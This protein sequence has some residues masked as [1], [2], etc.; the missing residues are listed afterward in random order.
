MRGLAQCDTK[1]QRS[2]AGVQLHVLRPH[3]VSIQKKIR[4]SL[5][6]WFCVPLREIANLPTL[7]ERMP[8]SKLLTRIQEISHKAV[9]D[10]VAVAFYDYQTSLRFAVRGDRPFHAASTF[11]AAVLLAVLKAVEEGRVRWDDR[12]QV[13]N[14]FLSIVDGSP[15]RIERTRDADASAHRAIGGSMSIRELAEVMV[16]RSSN[17][18]TNLLLD[19]VGVEFVRKVLD[20]AGV[21]GVEVKRGVEDQLA[22]DQGINNEVTAEGLVRLYRLIVDHFLPAELQA[23]AVR[24]LS[25]QEFNSMIPAKLPAGTR[26]AHK[27]GEISTHCHDAGIIFPAGRRPY[28]LA[29]LTEHGPEATRRNRAVAEISGAVY[30]YLAGGHGEEKP[31]A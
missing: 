11:K 4:V 21:R 22:H 29:I 18:A 24:I 26:V 15:Y 10:T 30:R 14:R 8:G 16:V 23:E 9:F 20:E 12:L 19:F 27:T 31:A 7:Q 5:A 17:L 28:V 6:V 3:G 13:R 1:N 2:C 25:A